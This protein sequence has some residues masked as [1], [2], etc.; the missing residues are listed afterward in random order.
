[1]VIIDGAIGEG[2]GQILRTCLSLSLITGQ[3]FRI[4]NIRSGRSRPGLRAQHLKAVE[5]AAEIGKAEVDG[6]HLNSTAL[7]FEPESIQAGVYQCKIGTA[8]STSLVLQTVYLPLSLASGD[9]VISLTGGTHVKWSPSYD[10]LS[11]HWLVF[12]NKIGFNMTLKLDSAGFYPQGGGSISAKIQPAKSI[13]PVELTSRGPLQ[14]IRGISAVANL[15]RRIAERQRNQIV[16]RLGSK[17]PLNDIRIKSFPSRFKGTTICLICEFEQSQCCYFSLGEIGKPAERVAN[18]AADD[19]ERF[20]S[21][22]A[23]IDEYLADQILL[24]L[25]FAESQ[26]T[27]STAKIT[28]HL[29]TNSAVIQEFLAV[30]IQIKGEIGSPGVI[31]VD[32]NPS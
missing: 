27:Y 23:A 12:L 1:M 11:Q 4:S 5:I 13:S 21:T 25:A 20:L 2:G 22:D 30:K 16:R 17:Y 29:L 31:T 18:E 8:G 15:D 14:K 26:S 24:P 28:D 32:P 10:Y 6:A 19:I 7:S 9:S 3:P